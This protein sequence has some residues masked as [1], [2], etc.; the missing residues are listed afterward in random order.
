[1]TIKTDFKD[2][3]ID[4][5]AVIGSD[6]VK[7]YISV[8]LKNKLESIDFEYDELVSLLTLINQKEEQIKMNK[9]LADKVSK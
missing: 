8:T 1:M 2:E 9:W 4:N 7:P 3:D 5:A 6:K